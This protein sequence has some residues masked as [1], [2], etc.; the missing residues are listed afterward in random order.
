M[1]LEDIDIA[2]F[3]DLVSVHLILLHLRAHTR[4]ELSIN[5]ILVEFTVGAGLG[6]PSQLLSKLV[7]FHGLVLF[8]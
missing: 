5:A 8:R 4:V 1:V 2:I 6:P 7:D 3:L